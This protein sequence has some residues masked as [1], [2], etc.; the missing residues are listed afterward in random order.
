M[1]ENTL[2][3]II[4]I[5]FDIYNIII[6]TSTI[7]DSEL[8]NLAE[9]VI[10]DNNAESIREFMLY[11]KSKSVK[12]VIDKEKFSIENLFKFAPKNGY[13]YNQESIH[14]SK[15]KMF[16]CNG[17]KEFDA[18]LIDSVNISSYNTYTFSFNVISGELVSEINLLGTQNYYLTDY[19]YLIRL[20][21]A[22]YHSASV[23]EYRY[24]K[25][26]ILQS[27]MFKQ[28]GSLDTII[29]ITKS[30]ETDDITVQVLDP[31]R[32]NERMS[33]IPNYIKMI[34]E[35]KQLIDDFQLAPKFNKK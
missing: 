7:M 25:S 32:A 31:V 16:E 1:E 27:I 8:V 15:Y 10:N 19:G 9:E 5:E 23:E 13:A 26:H 12:P 2:T 4:K 3:L 34:T 21:G 17:G 11:L 28:R 24:D 18:V 33:E 35:N 20:N 14:Y 22:G 30:K 6:F 29:E